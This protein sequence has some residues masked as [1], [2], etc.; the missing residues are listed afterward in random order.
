MAT[1]KSAKLINGAPHREIVEAALTIAV[2]TAVVRSISIVKELI[3][4]WRFGTSDD[5]DAF[6][7][8]LLV[9]IAVVSIVTSSLNAAFIPVYIH[10]RETE[11]KEAAQQLFQVVLGWALLL[12]VL[13]ALLI[14]LGAP[15][16]LPLIGSGFSAG[17]LSLTLKLVGLNA[18]VVLFSGIA[19]LCSAALN[20]ERRFAISA[21]APLATPVLT[22]CFLWL[23]PSWRGLA[24]I[25]GIVCGAAAEMLMLGFAL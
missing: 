12:L 9:P 11:G 14:V 8:S 7:I 16:Y 18:P 24:L 25:A 5:L 2:L 6:L 4:A 3:V 1:S 19:A 13:V 22:V 23:A 15:L 21:A 17:K 20:A 10:T